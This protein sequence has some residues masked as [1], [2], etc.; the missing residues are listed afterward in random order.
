MRRYVPGGSDMWQLAKSKVFMQDQVIFMLDKGLR[1]KE[2]EV[3][4]RS[5]LADSLTR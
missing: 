1:D 5:S 2:A 4:R 3:N